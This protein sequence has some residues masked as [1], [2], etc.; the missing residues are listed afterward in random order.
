M[1]SF[2]CVCDTDNMISYLVFSLYSSPVKIHLPLS[3][4]IK[5]RGEIS[6]QGRLLLQVDCVHNLWETKQMM[7]CS[8]F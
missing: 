7:P 5:H 6:V 1:Q 3:S 4:E 2:K 8:W